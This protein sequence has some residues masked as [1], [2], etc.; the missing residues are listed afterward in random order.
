[1]RNAPKLSTTLMADLPEK[2]VNTVKYVFQKCGVDYAGPFWYK[3]GQRKNT[4][5]IK[6][7]IALFI[8]LS[9][10][11]V[12]IELAADLSTETFLNV[13]KRFISRRGRPT[14][15]YSDNGLNFVGAKRELDEL[16]DLLKN[17]VLKQKIIDYMTSEK[18][19]WHFI[20]PRAPHMGGI[21]EAAIKS[22]KFHLKRIIGE[23]SLRY[24][25]LST[26]LAQVEAILNSR[27]LT[28]L[29]NDPN[30]LSALTRAHFLIECSIMTYPEPTIKELPTN[31]LSRWQSVEQLKQHFWHRW[32][33]EYLHN[34][35]A[36]VKWNTTND[37]IKVGQMVILQ[38]DLPPLCWSLARVE[39]IFPSKD[40]IIHVVSVRTPKG[41]YKRPITKLC[42]L[43]IE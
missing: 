2:R 13:F 28:P 8:C 24:D 36:R 38:E 19:R 4:K 42:I 25:E 11:A 10:K 15:I 34:C 35:Q 1:M 7:Y 16:Y 39:E 9:T 31:R 21:W 5:T 43:P 29:S 26:L 40:N 32:L 22:T 20:P 23:A 18:I 33:K 12:H 41:I 3:Q 6:C 14:D 27:P 37:P 30:D 17:D